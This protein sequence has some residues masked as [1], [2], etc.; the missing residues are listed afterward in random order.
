MPTTMHGRSATRDTLLDAFDFAQR[1]VRALVEKY[2]RD[3]YP[4][5]TVG[6]QYGQDRKRW[7]HWCDGF[8]PGMMFVFA[9]ATGDE[10]WLDDAIRFSTPLEERQYDRAVHDL[11]ILIFSTYLRWLELGG[12]A[13]RIERFMEKGQY[14]SSFV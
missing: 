13:E 7:T 12:P 4:M 3:Y 9:E 5:Y 11:G 2:P 6:G 1:Q 10:H 8:Y 14:L